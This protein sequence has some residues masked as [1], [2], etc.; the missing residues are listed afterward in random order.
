MEEVIRPGVEAWAA[1]RSPLEA[2]SALAAA[3]VA[4]GPVNDAAAIRADEHVRARGLIHEY[5]SFGSSTPTAVVGNPIVFRDRL[6]AASQPPASPPR[7]PLHA[8]D[9]EE[10]LTSRLGLDE[11]EIRS[12]RAEGVIQ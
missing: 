12:L 1:E 4:A 5:E 11:A 7:W 3:G 8:A 2:A 6:E 10:V 9:T